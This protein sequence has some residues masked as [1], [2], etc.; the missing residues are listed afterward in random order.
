MIDLKKKIKRLPNK[1]GVY[2]FFDKQNKLIYV[3]K[4]K[5]IKTRVNS[6]FSKKQ[7]HLKTATLVSKITDVKY[8]VVENETDALLLENNLI[9]KEK[10]KYNILL[11]DDKTYPWIC[12]SNDEFP[13]VFQTR[14]VKKDG[15]EYYGPYMSSHLV[16]LILDYISDMFYDNGWTP[17][18][19]LNKSKKPETK[20][21]Y[22]KIIAEARKI[23]RGNTKTLISNLSEKMTDLANKMAFEK[24]QK[25]KESIALIKKYQSKSV[26]V[27]SSL[28][29]IDVFSII[30]EEKYAY[31]NYLKIN[32][33]AV[34]I[35]HTIEI[36]KKLNEETG[37]ILKLAIVHLR[38]KFKSKSKTI[39]VPI[40]LTPIWEGVIFQ[41]PIRGEKK[42]LLNL[43]FLNTKHLKI[44]MKKRRL[45]STNKKANSR[46]LITLKK[47]L[48]LTALPIHIECFDNSNLN[49]TNPVAACVVF[50]NGL[51]AKKDY[52]NFNIQTVRI[53][54]LR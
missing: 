53:L 45:D 52:R 3:G 42:K 10:P 46:V 33:G 9:K 20:E 26:V 51:P 4:S 34:I 38:D 36:Q 50:R 29:N 13:K 14:I 23:I 27:S 31:I 41:I 16:K 21:Q 48:K 44:E 2:K 15:A 40:K 22:L 24:A 32:T 39:C 28:N 11:K 37:D 54:K 19:Y 12:I 47:D 7:L 17:F 5:N 8:V 6:Y 35:S 30:A 18:S 25:I 1:F 43:S 49:G